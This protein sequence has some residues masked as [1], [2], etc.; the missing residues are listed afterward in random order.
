[1]A[2]SDFEPKGAQPRLDLVDL[3]GRQ[4]ED[5]LAVLLLEL[6][7]GVLQQLVVGDGALV[8]VDIV[9]QL[10]EVARHV[11]LEPLLV[12][13]VADQ[14]PVFSGR[15]H[16]ALGDLEAVEVLGE[17][18]R[19]GAHHAH[20]HQAAVGGQR[21]D[22]GVQ[23]E[24]GVLGAL[25][26]LV[27]PERVGEHVVELG[28]VVV[29]ALGIVGDLGAGDV[30]GL[31]LLSHRP[32]LLAQRVRLVPVAG[33]HCLAQPTDDLVE[34]VSHHKARLGHAHGH[35]RLDVVELLDGLA[36]LG[37]VVN[38]A[39]VVA[40]KG[41]RAEQRELVLGVRRV[42]LQVAGQA[43]GHRLAHGA[44]DAVQERRPHHQKGG[45]EDQDKPHDQALH[46]VVDHAARG[47]QHQEPECGQ[48][49][50]HG[51]TSTSSVACQM[52]EMH[53]FDRTV[54]G[55]HPMLPAAS[56]QPRCDATPGVN[57]GAICGTT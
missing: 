10:V 37:E 15:D 16:L 47:R 22:L 1:M 28:D 2:S 11:V 44:L 8:V 51:D 48:E 33:A 12:G 14:E 38:L 4:P 40:A 31:Q 13:P 7:D 9:V 55:H 23:K 45:A 39:D 52:G 43:L 57:S 34:A 26:Q 54:R 36:D 42:H 18:L 29:V 50:A 30:L 5:D 41:D 53:R 24:Q 56:V 6:L 25:V 27:F 19:V 46:S 3:L 17:A 21:G 49:V 20:E 35:H 32:K